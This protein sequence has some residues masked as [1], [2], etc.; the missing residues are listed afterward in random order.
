LVDL[1]EELPQAPE[2]RK[3]TADLERGQFEVARKALVA[4]RDA[5]ARRP[6]D[7]TTQR[8]IAVTRYRVAECMQ[9]LAVQRYRE[10]R[11]EAEAEVAL[12][13]AA[14]VFARVRGD[15]CGTAREGSSLNAAAL[16][17]RLLINTTLYCWYRDL[18]KA[19]PRDEAY[20]KKQGDFAKTANTLLAELKDSFAGATF[21]D[22]RRIY[23]VA[24]A[25]A[26]AALGK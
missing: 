21:P 26:E 24:K 15:D 4:A 9:R 7:A 19:N 18:A 11:N 23:E 2:V 3:A 12:R 22:D 5:L 25:E 16:R 13:N 17:S 1:N 20:R 14:G 6:D 10:M 8:M